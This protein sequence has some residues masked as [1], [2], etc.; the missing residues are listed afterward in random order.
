MTS[1]SRRTSQD[2]ESTNANGKDCKFVDV[3]M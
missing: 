2:L 1:V 3:K